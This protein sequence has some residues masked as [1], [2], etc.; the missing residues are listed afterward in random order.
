MSKSIQKPKKPL[1]GTVIP[2]TST[3]DFYEFQK[4][5]YFKGYNKN[6]LLTLLKD[7]LQKRKF[8]LATR[9][10]LILFKNSDTSIEMLW[11]IGMEILRNKNHSNNH[12]H[13]FFNQLLS[14]NSSHNEE[15][16]LEYIF[17]CIKTE[18]YEEGINKLSEF[19]FLSP[20][21]ENSIL[22]GYSG[23][24]YF[25]LWEKNL[26]ENVQKFRLFDYRN[27]ENDDDE[28]FVSQENYKCSNFR[29]NAK[30]NF[31][32]S[33]GLN[34]HND[35]ILQYYIK[36]L[37]FEKHFEKAYLN[38]N[39][40]CDIN[41][42]NLIG[43]KLLLNFI[44]TY[45][46][47]DIKW[48]ELTNKIIKIDKFCDRE[49]IFL[50]LVDY[51]LKLFNKKNKKEMSKTYSSES[52]SLHYIKLA[53]E[54]LIERLDF[55]IDSFKLWEK[56][57]NILLII[58]EKYLGIDHEL[59]KNR[60]NWWKL[61]HFENKNIIIKSEDKAE[62]FIYRAICSIYIY[63][64]N[65]DLKSN[66]IYNISNNLRK[67]I[68]KHGFTEREIY[69]ECSEEELKKYI[70]S[71]PNIDI[72]EKIE[73]DK[74]KNEVMNIKTIFG[75]RISSY[76]KNYMNRK[77]ITNCEIDKNIK[78]YLERVS[79]QF[80][81][82]NK[83]YQSHFLSNSD[84]QNDVYELRNILLSKLSGLKAFYKN[85]RN[86][87][88]FYIFKHYGISIFHL[89]FLN[90]EYEHP[91]EASYFEKLHEL[92]FK[93]SESQLEKLKPSVTYINQSNNSKFLEE[94]QK[95][96][97]LVENKKIFIINQIKS[98][99]I[100]ELS[101][102]VDEDIIDSYEDLN[103][104]FSDTDKDIINVNQLITKCNDLCIK[105]SISNYIIKYVF[106][107]LFLTF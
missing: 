97:S 67:I 27:M 41:P 99:C 57:A 51:Y 100:E 90:F 42:N 82:L 66:Y 71:I 9:V 101:N 32:Q 40:F 39:N 80:N 5:R 87:N 88:A 4:R 93:L 15:I 23:I 46:Q 6:Q 84:Y 29:R 103:I 38:L 53:E 47:N 83:A 104:H 3:M 78:E 30:K 85:Y 76:L 98:N 26:P 60:R 14:L 52:S 86:I 94:N 81:F 50:P 16:L 58:N 31:E 45:S 61:F 33:L 95:E 63:G 1:F 48:V 72:K 102:T 44:K 21:K 35:F 69:P 64:K 75:K 36:I 24:L 25:I 79:N 37:I 70:S 12:C 62:F 17:Y 8:E 11:K 77:E 107:I 91:E 22:V 49:T 13:R 7:L 96:N 74:D 73:K 68:R 10:A 34:P 59:W 56:L 89:E 2:G 54:L 43:L 105:Y 92:L 28:E 65:M 106:D 55:E 18:Q 19:I 20:Y